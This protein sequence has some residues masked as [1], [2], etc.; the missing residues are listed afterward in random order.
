MKRRF[1]L[2]PFAFLAIAGV[3][4]AQGYQPNFIRNLL[5]PIITGGATVSGTLTADTV[6]ANVVDG[7]TLRLATVADVP[8]LSNISGT[9]GCGVAGTICLKDTLSL[10]TSAGQLAAT[11]T[12][13]NGVFTLAGDEDVDMNFTAAGAG[14]VTVDAAG[15]VTLCAGSAT[16]CTL[17]RTAGAT[18][19][20]G[21]VTFNGANSFTKFLSDTKAV[22][23]ASI[24][25]GT[26]ANQGTAITLTGAAAGDSCYLGLSASPGNGLA[27][28]CVTGS[29]T[30]QIVACNASAGSLTS[31]TGT[32]RC[33]VIH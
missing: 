25:A 10:A 12:P 19:V 2:L 15:A 5:S 20:A 13:G 28:S 24:N 32:H 6:R 30:C 21:T 1:P 3:V 33:T 27:Y 8:T 7:G 14:E 16:Q 9:A 29:N 23:G 11:A 31:L 26:C 22:T 17:G 4:V 18:N